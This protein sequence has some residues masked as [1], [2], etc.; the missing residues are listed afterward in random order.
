MFQSL[1]ISLFLFGVLSVVSVQ[2]LDNVPL[3]HIDIYMLCSNDIKDLD[4]VKQLAGFFTDLLP[5]AAD[6]SIANNNSGEQQFT[7]CAANVNRTQVRIAADGVA[8]FDTD[9]LLTQQEIQNLV[10]SDFL[11]AYFE[12]ICDDLDT[13]EA[14]VSNAGSEPQTSIEGA[15]NH[16][17]CEASTVGVIARTF[18]TLAIVAIL[19]SVIVVLCTLGLVCA[20]CGFCGHEEHERVVAQ[21]R[22]TSP[23]SSFV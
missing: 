23:R 19:S 22:T 15:M 20:C 1:F 7:E 10:S 17:F 8:S 12:G 21:T 18:Q 3:P 6:I 14:L 2:A 4:Y 9:N 16:F 5:S 13:F 11:E